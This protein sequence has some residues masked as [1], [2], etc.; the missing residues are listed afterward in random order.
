LFLKQQQ[1]QQQKTT[2]T[3]T[4]PRW[5]APEKQHVGCASGLHTHM[6]VHNSQAETQKGKKNA[7]EK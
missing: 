7:Q 5:I 1:Q 2:T 4:K 6:C 3:A